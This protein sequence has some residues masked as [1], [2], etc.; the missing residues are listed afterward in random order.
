MIAALL[1]GMKDGAGIEGTVL[2]GVA[3]MAAL[4]VVG[5]LLGAVARSVVDESVRAQLE[6]QL[7][8]A[9]AAEVA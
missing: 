5:A 3:A 1:R 9:D 4:A 6:K 2:H 7:A 8:E